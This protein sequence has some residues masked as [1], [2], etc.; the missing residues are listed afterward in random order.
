MR[1]HI[2]VIALCLSMAA[3]G[4][5]KNPLAPTAGP[6]PTT[7]VVIVTPDPDPPQPDPTPEPD[8]T[9]TPAPSAGD[10]RFQIVSAPAG[11]CLELGR[12]T[13]NIEVA[14]GYRLRAASFHDNKAGCDATTDRPG[15]S[16]VVRQEPMPA[17]SAGL[18]VYEWNTGGP[19][20]GRY[21]AD[22]A[23]GNYTDNE[24]QTIV[25]VVIDTGVD[26]E[27]PPPPTTC[28][29]RGD[30][31]KPPTCEELGNCPEPPTCEELGTC[32]EPPTCEELGNC[33]EPPT[34]EEL[35]TCPE[36]PVCV[37]VVYTG[38]DSVVLDN[39]SQATE[40]AFVQSF[41]PSLVWAGK[42]DG[43]GGNSWVSDGT[44]GV[45]LIKAGRSTYVFTNV[46][47]GDVLNVPQGTSHISRFNCP[48]E[49]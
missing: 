29:E 44:Y 11:A 2:A 36:P 26:C 35:G 25:G 28:E 3:C 8:P 40:T 16:F 24:W 34:C 46:S 12:H 19:S 39:S 31:P 41:A 43:D 47:P 22:I 10:P 49:N 15:G 32:P 45:V 33:P 21:Q 7:P 37:D 1:T 13:W 42:T 38:P 14:E 9:P 27:P 5:D 18:H 30:C 48:Q 4:S 6:E 17:Y 20:C 23:V